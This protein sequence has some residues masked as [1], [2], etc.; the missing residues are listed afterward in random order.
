MLVEVAVGENL[1]ENDHN[2]TE[3]LTVLPATVSLLMQCAGVVLKEDDFE[4]R[5]RGKKKQ[6]KK[7]AFE[8]SVEDRHNVSNIAEWEVK[9]H[10]ITL[11]LPAG[12]LCDRL[13]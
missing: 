3:K 5:G 12:T 9:K 2:E 7:K 8:T 1:K 13:K 6:F 10:F 4:E 11:E